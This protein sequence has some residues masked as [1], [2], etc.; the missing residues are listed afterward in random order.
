MLDRLLILQAGSQF[1][2]SMT[3]VVTMERRLGCTKPR[4]KRK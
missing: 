4:G 3:T 1:T 2:W